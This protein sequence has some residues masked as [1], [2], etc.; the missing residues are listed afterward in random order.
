MTEGGGEGLGD[1]DFG[2]FEG[3]DGGVV[4]ECPGDDGDGLGECGFGSLFGVGVG[5]GFDFDF[6]FDFDFGLCVRFGDLT[7]VL[8]CDLTAGRAAGAESETT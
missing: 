8:S 2:G 6:A 7:L 3:E 1:D 4:G 5:V